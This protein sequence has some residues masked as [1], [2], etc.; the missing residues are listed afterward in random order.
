M[1]T[2][3]RRFDGPRKKKV[4]SLPEFDKFESTN[5]DYIPNPAQNILLDKYV[6]YDDYL[7][8]FAV[9]SAVSR[10]LKGPS[11]SVPFIIIC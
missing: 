4:Y 5:P 10:G 7:V 2:A 6:C 11:P 9:D 8:A 1:G 3:A